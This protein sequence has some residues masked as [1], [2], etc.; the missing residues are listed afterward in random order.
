MM[1]TSSA[2]PIWKKIRQ[3]QLEAWTV[4]I[5]LLGLAVLCYGIFIPWFGLYGDD[6][7]YLYVY[8]LLGPGSYVNF[9]AA[10]RPLSAWIYIL[11]TSVFGEKIWA[12]HVFILILRWLGAVLLWR[13]LLEIWPEAHKQV[14]WVAFLFLVYPGFGQQPLPLEF[15][16]HFTVLDLF[17]LSLLSMVWSVQKR[18][19]YCPLTILGVLCSASMFSLE[20]FIGLELLR[21]VLLWIAVGQQPEKLARKIKRILFLWIPYLVILA[22]FVVWRVFIYKFQFYQPNLVNRFSQGILQGIGFLIIRILTDIKT[23]SVDAWRQ[24]FVIPSNLLTNVSFLAVVLG[25]FVGVAVYLVFSVKGSQADQSLPSP[26]WKEWGFSAVLLGLF[27]LLI[28]GWPFWITDI[29]VNL[30]FPWDRATI[31]FILGASLILAGFIALVFQPRLQGLVLAAIIGLAVGAHFQNATVYRDEWKTLQSYFW[32]MSWRAPE[33]KPGTVIVSDQIPLFRYSDNDLTAPLNWMYDASNH[34]DRLNYTF[35]DLSV[36]VWGQ[37]GFPQMKEGQP[38]QHSLRSLKFNG[39]SSDILVIYYNPPACLRFLTKTEPLPPGLPASLVKAT[40]IS[41]LDHVL[42]PAND[43]PSRPPAEL[44]SE[45]DHGWCYYFEKADLAYQQGDWQQIVNLGDQAKKAGL[46][47]GEMSE[48][49]PFIE[50]YAHLGQWDKAGTLTQAAW[51]SA[52]VQQSVCSTWSHIQRGLG[53]GSPDSTRV[54]KIQD[55]FGCS[56]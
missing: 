11:T 24:I 16:L 55:Q 18:R 27:A 49:L 20:Y 45:P 29:S 54:K 28:S 32:Q 30:S 35:Y 17:L 22:A 41:H 42:E 15:I 1:T 39:D 47:P 23:T 13:I 33:L 3:A 14:T 56:S 46:K 51:V 4:P 37:T 36:R 38:V 2:N 40:K 25:T 12:Y 44:G 34:S 21:P 5:A 19:W 10:D 48:Y 9:V 52:N 53:V 31:P 7:P 50:G 43:P 6:W 26:F 8:H